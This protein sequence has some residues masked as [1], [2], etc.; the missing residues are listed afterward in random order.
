MFKQTA[1]FFEEVA[2]RDGSVIDEVSPPVACQS[3]GATGG[4]N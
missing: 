2:R 3:C 4:R 1:C